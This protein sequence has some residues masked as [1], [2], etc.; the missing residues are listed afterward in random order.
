MIVKAR[1]IQGSEAQPDDLGN[2]PSQVGSDSA[3]QSGDAQGLSEI[4]EDAEVSVEELAETG[5]DYEAEVVEGIEQ[6]AEHPE[7]PVHTHQ[8]QRRPGPR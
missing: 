8:D 2:D 6:A 1:D 7:K 4:A 5:Q 3:G